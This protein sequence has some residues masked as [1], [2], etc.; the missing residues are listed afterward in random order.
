[1]MP[2][3]SDNQSIL[4]ALDQG[5][6]QGEKLIDEKIAKIGT[7]VNGWSY[8][9]DTGNY[10]TDYLLRAAVAKT[11]LTFVDNM[12]MNLTG[13]KKYVD[14]IRTKYHQ[15]MDFGLLRCTIQNI[16]M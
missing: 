9:L 4:K 10:G 7:V 6:I 15:S 2:S 3:K 11:A 8:N 5:I 1:M 13:S 14:L 12:G 16:C